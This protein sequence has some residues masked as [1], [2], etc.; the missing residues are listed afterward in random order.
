M[1]DDL[2]DSDCIARAKKKMERVLD[3]VLNL[4]AVHENNALIV[5]SPTL[6]SQIPRSFAA[7]AF[8]VFQH[9]MHDFEL[10]CAPCEIPPEMEETKRRA[11]PQS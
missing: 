2:S 1:F 5:F 4:V 9:V 7:N 8:N 11:F 6:A 3:H 10:V